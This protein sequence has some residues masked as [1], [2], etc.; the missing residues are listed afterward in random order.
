MTTTTQHHIL[1]LPMVGSMERQLEH[2]SIRLC[3][4]TFAACSS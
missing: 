2:A 3:D 1:V 4:I